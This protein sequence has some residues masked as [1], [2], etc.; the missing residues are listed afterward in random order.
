MEGNGKQP[1]V[2]ALASLDPMA[3]KKALRLGR[4]SVRVVLDNVLSLAPDDA[5]TMWKV[6]FRS[7][8]EGGDT[9]DFATPALKLVRD[10]K[11]QRP[12]IS[13]ENQ[14]LPCDSVL[15]AAFAAHDFVLSIYFDKEPESCHRFVN[16]FVLPLLYLGDGGSEMHLLSRADAEAATISPTRPSSVCEIAVDTVRAMEMADQA[17]YP[18]PYS[19]SLAGCC[20]AA[21]MAAKCR[22]MVT[23]QM[24]REVRLLV[25]GPAGAGKTTFV[26]SLL[27]FDET[28]QRCYHD[29]VVSDLRESG[30]DVPEPDLSSDTRTFIP[31]SVVYQVDGLDRPEPVPV[32]DV[33]E[34]IRMQAR[35]GQVKV[36]LV[37]SPGCTRDLMDGAQ[38]TG[39]VAES[40]LP[41]YGAKVMEEIEATVSITCPCDQESVSHVLLQSS[42]RCM[43]STGHWAASSGLCTL[44]KLACSRLTNSSFGGL[45]ELGFPSPLSAL[46]PLPTRRLWKGTSR[47][48]RRRNSE[49]FGRLFRC[50]R[51]LRTLPTYSRVKRAGT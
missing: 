4:A 13:K 35:E 31:Y 6:L 39:P 1:M 48:S 12:T 46:L 15:Q 29:K 42:T 26:S 30:T 32:G 23:E 5:A 2:D 11:V 28:Q 3:V 38:G 9:V 44:S 33:T 41:A 19:N 20:P 50:S 14:V 37:D 10:L 7:E 34:Y 43:D 47:M 24:Y 22:D 18:A 49:R 17:A 36:T 27:G 16:D 51:D 45:T 25:V 40:G 21:V 8:Q